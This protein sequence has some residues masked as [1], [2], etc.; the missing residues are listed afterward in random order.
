M[1]TVSEFALK[2]LLEVIDEASHVLYQEAPEVLEKLHNAKQAFENTTS[3][4]K[5]MWP[6]NVNLSHGVE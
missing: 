4:I 5:V 3:D 1:I 2:R 6:A